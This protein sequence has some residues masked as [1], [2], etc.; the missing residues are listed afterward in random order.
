MGREERE[1]QAAPPWVSTLSSYSR[2]Q[3]EKLHLT[4]KLTMTSL[5]VSIYSNLSLGKDF[6][7][8]LIDITDLQQGGK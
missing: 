8:S 5:G 4:H 1:G 6:L 2:Q 3:R 7:H